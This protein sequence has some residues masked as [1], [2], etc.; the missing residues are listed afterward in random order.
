MV[1]AMI[2]YG[3]EAPLGEVK[4]VEVVMD[5]SSIEK[6]GDPRYSHEEDPLRVRLSCLRR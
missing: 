6:S 3:V 5:A 4:A 2:S 1:K